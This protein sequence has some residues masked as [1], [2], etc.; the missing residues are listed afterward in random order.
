MI[1]LGLFPAEDM[2][3]K[4]REIANIVYI[5][6][7]MA[8]ISMF[9]CVATP[10]FESFHASQLQ[11]NKDALLFFHDAT[12]EEPAEEREMAD[13]SELEDTEIRPNNCRQARKHGSW[14]RVDP[15]PLTRG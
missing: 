9:V 12:C 10:F 4:P 8:C 2:Q 13:R 15:D 14:I 11:W 1:Q 3:N 6:W 7:F 5:Y